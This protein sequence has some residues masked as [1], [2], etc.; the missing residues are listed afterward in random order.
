MMF[1]LV[2]VQCTSSQSNYE[3]MFI[4]LLQE[5]VKHTVYCI[6]IMFFTGDLARS[7]QR[8]I[9]FTLFDYM[10]LRYFLLHASKLIRNISRISVEFYYEYK[11]SYS[12]FGVIILV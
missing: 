12:D 1:L 9:A 10:L 2:L 8:F 7:L 5:K 11:I 6:K 3:E 4:H